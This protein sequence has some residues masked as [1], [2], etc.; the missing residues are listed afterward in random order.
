MRG[1]DGV[2][3]QPGFD[4][5]PRLSPLVS[6]AT[7]LVGL[8]LTAAAV[9]SQATALSKADY[10]AHKRQIEADF[11]ADR[12]VCDRLT[13]NDRDVCIVKAKGRERVAKSELDFNNTGTASDANRL[14]VVK[15]D[16]DRAVA[17]ELCDRRSGKDKVLCINDADVVHAKAVQDI[18][19]AGAKK[20]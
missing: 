19:R 20:L 3:F 14:A 9:P 7:W 18:A 13:D 15:A 17:R 6:G 4:M 11:K 10:A 16:A 2:D 5:R 12:G 1:E 8:I